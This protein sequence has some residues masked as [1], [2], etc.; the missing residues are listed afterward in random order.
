M[1]EGEERPY[2]LRVGKILHFDDFK[3]D[4]AKGYFYQI[5]KLSYKQYMEVVDNPVTIPF[6]VPLFDNKFLDLC[7]R[8]TWRAIL[9][10]WV[11]IALY[12]IYL[13]LT[14]NYEVHSI[15]D[16]YVMIDSPSFSLLVVAAVIG[17]AVLTW[18][19][20]EY[21]L[22]RFLFHM[23]KWMPD[24]ALYRYLA[25][26]IH[27]VH[28]ALPMDGER[29]VFPPSLGALM[30]Y[31]LTNIIYTFLPGNAGRLFVFGFMCAYIHYDMMHYYLH[32]N[33]PS[34]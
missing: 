29:L 19:L 23:E 5:W 30:Y 21:S 17:F 11:P 24:Q 33:N 20:A 31:I 16:N 32:H 15:I 22:H 18:S 27:G 2:P 34:I 25:F 26:I 10:L 14:F 12:H 6:Y 1:R 3:I 7:S 13:S 28:H 4:L 8:T 9:A